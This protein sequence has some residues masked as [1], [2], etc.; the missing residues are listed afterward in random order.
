MFV[1]YHGS[2]RQK[3]VGSGES[4]SMQSIVEPVRGDDM[5]GSKGLR[6]REQIAKA[7]LLHILFRYRRALRFISGAGRKKGAGM[8]GMRETIIFFLR[9]DKNPERYIWCYAGESVGV[10][11]FPY[12]D[13][14]C[15]DCFCKYYPARRG[16]TPDKTVW[17]INRFYFYKDGKPAKPGVCCE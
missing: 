17:D 3:R 8:E 13:I 15:F 12:S 14:M 9:K 6:I 5:G 1:L 16:I 2:G 11:L 7:R 4:M 10:C